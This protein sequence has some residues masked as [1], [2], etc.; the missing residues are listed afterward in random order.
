MYQQNVY[1]YEGGGGGG[2]GFIVHI[3]TNKLVDTEEQNF[4]THYFKLK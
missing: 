2:G 4:E 1:C 3:V